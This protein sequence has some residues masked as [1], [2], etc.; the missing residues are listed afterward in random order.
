MCIVVLEAEQPS[1]SIYLLE[2][3]WAT[4]LFF[5]NMGLSRPLFEFIFPIFL[6]HC[7]RNFK[8]V[9]DDRKWER[10]R[11]GIAPFYYT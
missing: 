8:M 10:R 6:V 1:G 9:N 5:S 2:A 3:N 7:Y 4:R 11:N